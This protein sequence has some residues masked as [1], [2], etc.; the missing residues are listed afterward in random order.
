[1][2]AAS[3]AATSTSGPVVEGAPEGGVG[4]LVADVEHGLGGSEVPGVGEGAGHHAGVEDVERGDHEVG[5]HRSEGRGPGGEVAHPEALEADLLEPGL[6]VGRE[7]DHAVDR[8]EQLPQ[9]PGPPGDLITL[10]VGERLV[11]HLRPHALRT[12]GLP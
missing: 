6:G 10:A 2:L 8:F 5:A 3:S 1:M 11:H 7:V 4:Q 12:L 9:L